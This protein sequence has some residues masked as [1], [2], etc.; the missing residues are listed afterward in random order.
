MP[1]P[2]DFGL[3][4]DFQRIV[5]EGTWVFPGEAPAL[6]FV[7][8]QNYDFWAEMDRREPEL[9]ADGLAYYVLFNRPAER[10]WWVE[11][12][13]FASV[14]EAMEWA[15]EIVTGPITWTITPRGTPV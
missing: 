14:Q 13:G 1:E 4:P 5:C 6:V 8:E 3:P 12:P 10:P 9:N 7:I 11:S 15:G 2:I